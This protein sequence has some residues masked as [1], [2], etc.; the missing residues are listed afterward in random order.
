MILEEPTAGTP[1][2]VGYT[3]G[4]GRQTSTKDVCN[5]MLDYV[6]WI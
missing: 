1:V 4:L 2:L 5:T 6:T 3:T